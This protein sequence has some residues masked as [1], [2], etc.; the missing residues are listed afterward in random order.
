MADPGVWSRFWED[1]VGRF[2]GPMRFRLILQPGV[3]ILLAIRAG[4][5]DLRENRPP[6]LWA[7]VHRREQRRE[8]LR[9]GWRDVRTVFR[10]CLVMDVIYQLLVRHRVYPLELLVTGVFLAFIPYVLVRGPIA[11]LIRVIKRVPPPAGS[12]PPASR[13][14]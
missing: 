11:R 14:P 9:R 13:S 4:L 3:V 6:Y 10:V 1:L 5:A 7:L 12:P 8:L 2:T